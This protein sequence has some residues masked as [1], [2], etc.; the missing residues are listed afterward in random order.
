MCVGTIPTVKFFSS[1][2]NGRLDCCLRVI[3]PTDEVF[4]S[5]HP[6]CTR[7][8]CYDPIRWSTRLHFKQPGAAQLSA[9]N[10]AKWRTRTC[11]P[12]EASVPCLIADELDVAFGSANRSNMP[13]NGGTYQKVSKIPVVQSCSRTLAFGP[14]I[15]VP[16]Q[17]RSAPNI[18][19]ERE[20]ADPRSTVN[21]ARSWQPRPATR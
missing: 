3:V 12:M 17:I 16:T 2:G 7:L 14:S 13:V 8:K 20:V 18:G 11:R 6:Q 4:K 1:P 15:G 19:A 10:G 5:F 9:Q 21:C